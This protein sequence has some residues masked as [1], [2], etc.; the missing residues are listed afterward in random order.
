MTC[1]TSPGSNSIRAIAVI[2]LSDTGLLHLHVFV[3]G[4]SFAA[5]RRSLF[6]RATFSRVA[7]LWYGSPSFGGSHHN[8]PSHMKLSFGRFMWLG[9][10]FSAS[11]CLF[12]S[13]V[14]CC[15]CLCL[16]LF[17]VFWPLGVVALFFPVFS[18]CRGLVGLGFTN[19]S[20]PSDLL[21]S[22]G[23]TPLVGRSRS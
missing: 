23:V 3:F 22:R 11:L 13:A 16:V 21:T 17:S 19:L 18:C 10:P 8:P 1:E 6:S 5:S 4:H 15:R 20:L 2:L 7:G 12:V 14:C 9:S